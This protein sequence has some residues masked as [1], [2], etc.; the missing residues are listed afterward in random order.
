MTWLWNFPD[1]DPPPGSQVIFPDHL[2][3]RVGATAALAGL[4]R[5]ERDGVG[6]HFEAAQVETVLACMSQYFLKESLDPGSV[7]PCGNRR[8]Q[9]A[10]WGVYRCAGEERWVVITCRNDEDWNGLRKA[11]GEPDWAADP[12]L[13]SAEGRRA[14]HDAIDAHLS[15][16][17]SARSDRE[18]M[19]T[20]QSFGVPAGMM[21]YASDEPNDPHLQARGYLAQ[22]DQPG[23]G[24]MILEGPAFYGSAMPRPFIGPAPELGEHTREIAVSLLGLSSERAEELI[25]AGVLEV[26]PPAVGSVASASF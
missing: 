15:A 25:A 18:V 17:T 26:T 20:L 23:I 10:P 19:E 16:W 11:L 7:Q 14:A 8:E 13:A 4:V 24:R 12:A 5:R 9:G 1:G 2:V 6:T 3:G 22:V 21:N